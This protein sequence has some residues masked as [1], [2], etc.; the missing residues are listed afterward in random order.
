MDWNPIAPSAEKVQIAKFDA[1]NPKPAGVHYAADRI[2]HGD[3]LPM[4]SNPLT[5]HAEPVASRG[6]KYE[7]NCTDSNMLLGLYST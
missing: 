7:Q 1:H 2:G 3:C 5:S 4:G 6:A